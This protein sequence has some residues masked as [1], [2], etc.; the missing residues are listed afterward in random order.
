MRWAWRLVK[1][2]GGKSDSTSTKRPSWRQSEIDAAKNH[3]DYTEQKSFING[4]EVPYGT[5]QAVLID[6]RGQNVLQKDLS[7][8]YNDVMKR[9]NNGIEVRFRK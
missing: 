1:P 8:L 7:T 6:V 2:A 9:T 3:P 4:K 5:K